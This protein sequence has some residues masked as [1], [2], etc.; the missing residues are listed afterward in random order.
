MRDRRDFVVSLIG[1][2]VFVVVAVALIA[3]VMAAT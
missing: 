1:Y 3:F 2:A